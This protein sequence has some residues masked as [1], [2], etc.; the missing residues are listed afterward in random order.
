MK[1][2][3][4]SAAK[5][6][7]VLE[8]V[9]SMEHANQFLHNGRSQMSEELLS[10]LNPYVNFSEASTKLIRLCV[11]LVGMYRTGCVGM[12]FDITT[13]GE[14]RIPLNLNELLGES[15]NVVEKKAIGTNLSAIVDFSPRPL[16]STQAIL[17][18]A[19]LFFIFQD[20][21]TYAQGLAEHPL[22][23]DDETIASLAIRA[24]AIIEKKLELEY[25][26]A[27]LDRFEA[28]SVKIEDRN[29]AIRKKLKLSLGGLRMA[30]KV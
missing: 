17:V 6:R 12:K 30:H 1:K 15:F 28:S 5:Y 9:S 8:V 19:D 18:L 13:P 23:L 16:S 27:L 21:E 4:E 29:P 3:K 10:G 22:I 24:L 2:E 20:P 14:E 7:R 26:L 11:P 25:F